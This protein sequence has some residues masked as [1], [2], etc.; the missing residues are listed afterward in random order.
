MGEGDRVVERAAG[1]EGLFGV[2]VEAIAECAAAVAKRLEC[3][4][5]GGKVGS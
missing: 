4:C 2:A 5:S 3:A 1:T